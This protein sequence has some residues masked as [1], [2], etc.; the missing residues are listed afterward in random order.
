MTDL[1]RIRI[2][3]YGLLTQTS[4]GSLNRILLDRRSIEAT[5]A[6]TTGEL[7][8]LR[9]LYPELE[10]FFSPKG[11]MQFR[12][13]VADEQAQCLSRPLRIYFNMETG[14][15]L[16]CSF[17]GP[18]DFRGSLQTAPE[19]LESKLLDQIAQAGA[20]QVQL[21]GGEMFLRGWRLF[22]VLERT[23][24]LGLA[25]LLATNG[26]WRHIEHR[27]GFLKKLSEFDHVI[28]VK[29]SL[30][31]D[32]SFHDSVR[33]LGTYR[34][35]VRTVLD[36]SNHGFPVRINTTIFRESCTIAQIE[37]V[38]G[39]AKEAGAKLQAIPER[40]CG[41]AGGKTTYQLPSPEAL[42]AYTLRA[43]ELRKELGIGISFN[44]DVFGGG[45]IL[46]NYDPERPFSCGAGL[47]GFAVTH[48]GEVYPCGFTMDMHAPRSFLAGIVSDR[49]SL[50]DIWLRSPLLNEWRQAGK[51]T[52][53][54]TCNHY[55]QTCWGGCM[56]Q[57]F[58]T[59]GRLDAHD[60][61]CSKQSKNVNAS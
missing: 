52:E 21:T 23:R 13:D 47:W 8:R 27:N 34:E 40:S 28:E 38:A 42:Q 2:D 5:K 60:P 43:T 56:V 35:A 4:K 1:R 36:L 17:C 48:L 7:L 24:E 18:R 11:E 45:R 58:V 61:Y 46:P 55:G 16:Q 44:F 33:G 14:C 6:G 10:H 25:T 15:N 51:S 50:L 37:H 32:E 20:F 19:Q 31:G 26:V 57:A 54:K 9:V 3:N 29:V 59:H 41:R 30:D 39:I 12:L 53:C 49:C 22:S